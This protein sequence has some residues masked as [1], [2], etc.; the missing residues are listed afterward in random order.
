M[1]GIMRAR[2]KTFSMAIILLLSTI[3]MTFS[4]IP[5]VRAVG[6]AV[7][8]RLHYHRAD[9][10]YDGWTVWIWSVGGEGASYDLTGEDDFGRYAE[11]TVPTGA[12]ELGYIVRYG[13]WEAKDIDADQFISIA[14]VVSG[15]VNAYVESGVE[16]CTIELSDDAVT[17]IKVSS[18]GASSATQI[19]VTVTVDPSEDIT[20]DF[21]VKDVDGNNLTIDH[22]DKSG[23][24]YTITLSDEMDLKK[25]YYFSYDGSDLKISMPDY[26]STPDFESQYTY[27]GDDLGATWTAE[28]T[29]FR[30][31][32]PTA[33]AVSVNLYKSGTK[34]TDDLIEAIP[35][36]A[37]VNGTW[38]AE[39][40]GDQNGT[41]YTYTVSVGGSE[42]S[43]F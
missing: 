21:S 6:D 12:T 35:M 28:K 10:N 20:G 7:T 15:T 42:K 25:T 9:S 27:E 19:T 34:G 1:E 16:G 8:L 43:R 30:V 31:W 33:D 32:A 40:T 3:L 4:D 39:K 14:E 22:V 38:I 17:G 11:M 26:Y 23:R 37:D 18:A 24:T 5:E 36:T 2:V 29:S 41:Y 13:E